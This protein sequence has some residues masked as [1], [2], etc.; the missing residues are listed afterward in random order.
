M[1]E[2]I[3]IFNQKLAWLRLLRSEG[4]GPVT[5]W[6]LLNQFRSAERAL[7]ALPYLS[8]KGRRRKEGLME[9]QEDNASFAESLSPKGEDSVREEMASYE[10]RGILLLAAF[11]SDFPA[12]LRVL[13]DC[14]PFIS[15]FGCVETLKRPM[16]ALVGARNA[17]FYGSQ[18][19]EKLSCSL[20][21]AGWV[22]VSGLAKGIDYHAHIG[23]LSSARKGEKSVAVLPG[24]VDQIYPADHHEL[25]EQL[26]KEGA[27]ISE[28]PLGTPPTAS[29]FSRR[30]RL[31]SG[32]SLGVIVVEAAL[33]SGSL[34][35]ARYGADQGREIF[36][37][38]GSPLDPRAQGGNDLLRNGAT[39]VESVEDVEAVLGLP[40]T[41]SFVARGK[42]VQFAS[43]KTFLA[44]HGIASSISET[45]KGISPESREESSG[46]AIEVCELVEE[47]KTDGSLEGSQEGN[48]EVSEEG[49][50]EASNLKEMLLEALSFQ[51]LAIDDLLER[52]DN[53]RSEIFLALT[54]L[55]LSGQI[56][57]ISN[58]WVS[59]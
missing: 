43:S 41:G 54:L 20:V 47:K 1:R 42:G 58:Q 51:P 28:M 5:F 12:G 46:N 8:L 15:V 35:T 53:R 31:I 50:D 57:R 33:K 32:M 6:R 29:H 10:K 4:V 19:A 45:S 16:I 52:Y 27:L 34:I 37:V 24:G 18:F 7:E 30:N 40:G 38:P 55:E 23:A 14:P 49:I 25:Y 56:R 2:T 48:E 44:S 26:G 59:L 21:D 22:V 17:S 11:E 3:S 9:T 36:A 13:A 39:L